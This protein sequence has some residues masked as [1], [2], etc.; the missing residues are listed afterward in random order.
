MSNQ[1]PFNNPQEIFQAFTNG[2]SPFLQ[3]FAAN[4]GPEMLRGFMQAWNTLTTQSLQN[5]QQW[6][7]IMTRYQQEQMSL[8]LKMLGAKPGEPMEPAVSSK[9]GDR[10][11]AAPE[12]N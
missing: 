11:F 8:W 5:P 3:D 2:T 1:E 12:W 9:P 6:V 10:R 7:E 4:Q